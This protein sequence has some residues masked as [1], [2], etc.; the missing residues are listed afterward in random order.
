MVELDRLKRDFRKLDFEI[1]PISE[2]H[3]GIKNV[4]SFYK[5]YEIRHLLAFYDYKNSL[6]EAM[7]IP[8]V[9]T[10]IIINTDGKVVSMITGT[11]NW[12]DNK[13]R[14]WLMSHVHNI[15]S[16]D[17]HSYKDELVD[18]EINTLNKILDKNSK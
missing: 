6:F 15:L 8:G 3:Q 1:L 14:K 4:I 5:Y 2:D 17:N 11:P 12:N 18:K 10:S 16:E 13:I 9:P 7:A